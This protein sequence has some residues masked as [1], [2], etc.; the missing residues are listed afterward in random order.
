VKSK[1][2][3][4]NKIKEMVIC[5]GVFSDS[6]QSPIGLIPFVEVTVKSD[7]PSDLIEFFVSSISDIDERLDVCIK[8]GLWS[9]SV[10]VSFNLLLSLILFFD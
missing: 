8:Y 5:R 9:L 7:G 2:Q 1:L 3:D 10:Q 4:W 6:I